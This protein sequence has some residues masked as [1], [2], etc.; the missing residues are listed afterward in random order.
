MKGFCGFTLLEVMIAL[1][2]LAI[3]LTA[4]LRNQAQSVSMGGEARYLTVASLLARD[5]MALL[6]SRQGDL[7]GEETGTFEEPWSDFQWKITVEKTEIGKIRKRVVAVF[8]NKA[9]FRPYVIELY[10]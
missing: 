3:V 1:A 4:T 2:I 9:G 5:K 7:P 6:E 8:M 10:R